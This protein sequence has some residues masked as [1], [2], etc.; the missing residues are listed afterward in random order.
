MVKSV[1]F[2]D[3]LTNKKAFSLLVLY[4][5]LKHLFLFNITLVNK[6]QIVYN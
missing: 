2:S 4:K 5:Q 3:I 6:G 1:H